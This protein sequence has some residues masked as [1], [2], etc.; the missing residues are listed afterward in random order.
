MKASLPYRAVEGVHRLAARVL[1]GAIGR[2]WRTAGKVP[3]RLRLMLGFLALGAML[4]GIGRFLS[5][6][7]VEWARL[8]AENLRVLG[9]SGALADLA[10]MEPLALGAALL[11]AAAALLCWLR[12]RA[13]YRLL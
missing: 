8:S 1:G 7:Y 13:V 2:T 9:E 12:R 11:C 4:A 6:R 3:L 5:A 10:R